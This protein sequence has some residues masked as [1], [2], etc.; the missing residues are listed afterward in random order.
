MDDRM[1]ATVKEVHR[2]AIEGLRS[3]GMLDAPEP[4]IPYFELPELD[5]T[6]PHYRAW[7]TYRRVVEKLLADGLRG[8]WLVIRDDIVIGIYPGPR[9]ASWASAAESRDGNTSILIKQILP[10]EPVSTLE[11]LKASCPTSPIP[12]AKTA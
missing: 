12:L 10:N 2:K 8:F 5:P 3:A 1:L 9:L 6:S 7:N 4:P 11:R